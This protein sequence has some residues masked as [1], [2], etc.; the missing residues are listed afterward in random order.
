VIW[1]VALL[2]AHRQYGEMKCISPGVLG[3]EV[4]GFNA[5]KTMF[6]SKKLFRIEHGNAFPAGLYVRAFR[7]YSD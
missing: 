6:P 2:L 3:V 5:G 7:Y 1:G 4:Q